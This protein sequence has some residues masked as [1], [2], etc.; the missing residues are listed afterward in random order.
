VEKVSPS[1]VDTLHGSPREFAADLRAGAKEGLY[2]VAVSKYARQKA[3][4][5]DW[6]SVCRG[7]K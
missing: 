2:E 5:L 4:T 6:P 1:L 7:S 3:M